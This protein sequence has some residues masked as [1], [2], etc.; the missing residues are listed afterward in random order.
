MQDTF[1]TF[2]GIC[3]TSIYVSAVFLLFASVVSK[4]AY[5]N[6]HTHTH[7]HT[8]TQKKKCYT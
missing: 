6:T 2:R 3:H 4:C 8:H 7:S 5:S 1:I